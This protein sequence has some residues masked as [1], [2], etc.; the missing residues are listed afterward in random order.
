MVYKADSTIEEEIINDLIR[1][2]ES[3]DFRIEDLTFDA[4]KK[5]ENNVDEE[6]L[7]EILEELEGEKKIISKP[8][9]TKLYIPKQYENSPKIKSFG[10]GSFFDDFVRYYFTGTIVIVILILTVSEISTRINSL[11]SATPTTINIFTNGIFLSFLVPFFLGYLV[12]EG[13]GK[14]NN[15]LLNRKLDKNAITTVVVTSVITLLSYLALSSYFYKQPTE[16]SGILQSISLGFVIGAFLWN[17][18]LKKKEK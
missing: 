6:K 4:I 18:V 12:V 15:M 3:P 16:P 2:L 5:R 17:F 14:L 8:S 11:F 13:Y 7:K 9:R 10:L 1:I